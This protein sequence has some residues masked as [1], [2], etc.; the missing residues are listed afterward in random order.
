MQSGEDIGSQFQNYIY[1]VRQRLRT[2]RGGSRILVGQ[3]GPYFQMGTHFNYHR[4]PVG[5][6][7]D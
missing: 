1:G 4:R 2:L 6:I 3:W 5:L 7:S